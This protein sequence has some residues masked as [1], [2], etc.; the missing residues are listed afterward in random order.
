MLADSFSGSKFSSEPKLNPKVGAS[1]ATLMKQEKNLAFSERWD[2][3]RAND[4]GAVGFY[5]S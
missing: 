2:L 3:P 5:E 4:G 1:L